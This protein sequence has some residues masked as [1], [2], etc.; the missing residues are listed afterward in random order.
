LSRR[1]EG[2]RRD[3]ERGSNQSEALLQRGQ[4]RAFLKAMKRSQ[5]HL[6]E[7]LPQTA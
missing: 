4:G 1:N 2:A 5:K 6:S 7:A 3:T